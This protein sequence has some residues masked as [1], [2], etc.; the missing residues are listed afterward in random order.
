MLRCLPLQQITAVNF[1]FGKTADSSQPGRKIAIDGLQI[2]IS[3]GL[4]QRL[5]G[6]AHQFESTHGW[7]SLRQRQ[8]RQKKSL[9][10][11]LGIEEPMLQTDDDTIA[12]IIV[13]T[14]AFAHTLGLAGYDPRTKNAYLNDSERPWLI[15]VSTLRHQS[16]TY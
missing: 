2:T 8:Q 9:K 15:Y 13:R 16:P 14:E 7:Y 3:S 12:I 11:R 1:H 4:P 5:T 6:V 10:S